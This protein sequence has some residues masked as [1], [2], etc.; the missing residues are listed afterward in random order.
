MLAQSCAQGLYDSALPSSD[1]QESDYSL[2]CLSTIKLH[3]GASPGGETT[4]TS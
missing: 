1:E 4:D 3:M 2:H